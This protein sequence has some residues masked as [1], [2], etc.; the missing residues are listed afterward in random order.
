LIKTLRRAWWNGSPICIRAHHEAL[1][2][3]EEASD[4][5]FLIID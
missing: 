4:A 5:A 3:F 1:V 2:E